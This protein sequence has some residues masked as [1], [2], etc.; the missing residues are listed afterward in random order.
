M[1]LG[2]SK[3]LVQYH[4]P[5]NKT[6]GKNSLNYSINN[7]VSNA[8][9]NIFGS[10]LQVKSTENDIDSH[11]IIQYFFFLYSDQAI[12]GKSTYYSHQDI[13]AELYGVCN[14]LVFY[15]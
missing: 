2:L 6:R 1:L 9:Q 3:Q 7:D 4:A 12:W 5:L 8:P 11:L 14:F 10:S 15:V 13:D